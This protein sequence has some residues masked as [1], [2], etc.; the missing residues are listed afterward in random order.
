VEIPDMWNSVDQ[1][2]KLIIWAN[3]GIAATLLVAFA[4]TVVAIKAGSRKDQLTAAEDLEKSQ[5]IADTSERAGKLE[6]ANLILRSQIASVETEMAKQQERAAIAERSLLQLRES[7]KD[8]TI[9]PAQHKILVEALRGAPSGPVDVWWTASDTDSFG[10]AKQML[11]IF[12]EAGWPPAT[13]HF[14]AGGTG[15]G[16]FIA[17]HDRANAPAYAVSIQNAY[18]LIGID[19]NGFSKADVPEGRVQIYIG[20]KTPAK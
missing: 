7:L 2:S 9:S 12:K 10:L 14:A 5:R 20:H 11:E 13:E 16:I 8:R 4:C 3:W 15:N 1:L 19:M 17:V 6:N 18:R